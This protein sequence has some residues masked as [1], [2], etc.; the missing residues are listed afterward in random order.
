VPKSNPYHVSDK[1]ENPPCITVMFQ[2]KA[3]APVALLGLASLGFAAFDGP[4][5]C[6]PSG[7]PI[8][9]PATQNQ[10]RGG[11]RS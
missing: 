11:R 5:A 4:S 10:R 8:E 9:T 2:Y 1:P 7:Q 6:T 3:Q